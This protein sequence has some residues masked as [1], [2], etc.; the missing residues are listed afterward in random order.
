MYS[1]IVLVLFFYYCEV[2]FDD[3]VQRRELVNFTGYSAIYITLL[4][5][6]VIIIIT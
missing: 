2:D 6:I 5:H 1:F 4:L 3:N